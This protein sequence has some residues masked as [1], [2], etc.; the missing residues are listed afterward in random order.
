MSRKRKIREK[1]TGD[2]SRR[3]FLKWALATS[4]LGALSILGLAYS[5]Q[6]TQ[7][8][9]PGAEN[10]VLQTGSW[11]FAT[12][13][14]RVKAMKAEDIRMLYPPL[15]GPYR[16]SV[17]SPDFKSIENRFTDTILARE[18]GKRGFDMGAHYDAYPYIQGFG[19]PLDTK[20]AEGYLKY[21]G[22]AYEHLHQRIKGLNETVNFKIV[23]PSDNFKSSRGNGL[24]VETW[25][26]V[27]SI[28]AV[29]SE[30]PVQEFWLDMGTSHEN[31]STL[32]PW[33]EYSWTMILGAGISSLDAAVSE[34][35]HIYTSVALRKYESETGLSQIEIEEAFVHGAAYFMVLELIGKLHIPDG[36]AI[37]DQAHAKMSKYAEYSLLPKAKAWIGRNN[38]QKG[39]DL[40]MESPRRFHEA[41]MKG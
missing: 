26:D 14:I 35:L 11:D 21:A 28:K 16:M 1:R 29:N 20:V 10:R 36:K 19:V 2:V 23:R 27:F 24:I 3:S 9:Q 12:L 37:L 8:P 7:Y 6:C 15:T 39:F 22:I 25:H 5:R 33:D 4:T 17:Y 30:N 40:Y 38:I 41:I 31:G 13:P 32:I 18:V 34:P